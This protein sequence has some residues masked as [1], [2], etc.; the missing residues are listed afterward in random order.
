MLTGSRLP[1]SCGSPCHRLPGLSFHNPKIVNSF[2]ISMFL[3][4]YLHISSRL[5]FVTALFPALAGPSVRPRPLRSVSAGMSRSAWTRRG[6][7]QV[8][9]LAPVVHPVPG[10]DAGRGPP[11]GVGRLVPPSVFILSHS[12]ARTRSPADAL[13]V[14]SCNHPVPSG[15]LLACCAFC[16]RRCPAPYTRGNAMGMALPLRCSWHLFPYR[17]FVFLFGDCRPAAAFPM[18]SQPSLCCHRPPSRRCPLSD[19]PAF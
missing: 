16:L 2:D 6:V 15:C 17:L 12:R 19:A 18:G 4:V 3:P 9:A 8:V 1:L 13:P 14:L 5:P 7:R 10:W 11:D